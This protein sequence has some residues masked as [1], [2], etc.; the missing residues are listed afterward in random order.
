MKPSI[1]KYMKKLIFTKGKNMSKHALIVGGTS[2]IGLSLAIKLAKKGYQV[3]IL[4]RTKPHEAN[5]Y[6]NINYI[7]CNLID[8][9]DE[10]FTNLSKN[11]NIGLLF[12]TAGIGRVAD[13]NYLHSSEIEKNFYVN[14]I[15]PI[16]IFKYFYDIILNSENF[17][18]GIISS[19]AGK[20]VSPSF[21][22]YAATKSSVSSFVESINIELEI[23]KSKNRILDVSPG[24][25]AGTK[26]YGGENNLSLL[27][28]LSEKI[29]EKLFSKETLYIPEYDN[30]YK[31]IIENYR[32]SPHDF[33]ISSYKY[34][35]ENGRILNRSDAK[36]GY[37]SGTFDLFHV[38]HLNLLRK[39]KQCCDY[40]IVGVHNDGKW[41][42][43][44]TFIPLNE[45]KAIISSC[46]YVDKV[47]D[48]C[49]E[50]SDAWNLWHYNM[51]FVG[52]D[53][54]GSERFKRYEKILKEKNVEIIYFP[55]TQ[56]TS[57]TKIRNDIIKS[58]E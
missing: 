9:D 13:F 22:V 40:L 14:A 23:K 57:S 5:I 54:K 50:D 44:E 24:F 18:S 34:K 30:I 45:R 2:G 21:S 46:K 28:C 31:E 12:I 26:F 42:G 17:Y 3:D 43:K 36:I 15:S 51:L 11:E 55:Y 16:K 25:F 27:D 58:T 35:L 4:G 33:G 41:K 53:Y 7:F 10:L 8:F 32:K 1:G 48:S 37:L 29:L 56:S 47:V 6:P 49:P 19:I 39:A 52:S 20:I 38:G